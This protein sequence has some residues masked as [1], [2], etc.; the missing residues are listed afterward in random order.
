MSM[1]KLPL[2]TVQ[3]A[4]IRLS[5]HYPDSGHNAKSLRVIAEDWHESFS[6]MMGEKTFLQAVKM[7]RGRSKG[8]FPNETL[9]IEA[10]REINANPQQQSALQIPERTTEHEFTREEI[11]RN[12][13]RMTVLG[14]ASAGVISMEEAT[15]QLEE[16]NSRPLSSFKGKMVA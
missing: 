5:A 3:T 8:F 13:A 6:T 12:R 2:K 4:L 11:A 16:I 1:Y 10:A 14:D 7:A 15:R 9:I